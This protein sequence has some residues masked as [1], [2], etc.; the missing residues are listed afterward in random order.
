M[1]NEN[2]DLRKFNKKIRITKTVSDDGAVYKQLNEFAVSLQ[3][4][5]KQRLLTVSKMSIQ[6]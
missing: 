6:F 4:F 5:K 2:F 3:T 1:K